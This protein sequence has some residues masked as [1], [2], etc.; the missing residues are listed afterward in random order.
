MRLSKESEYGLKGLVFLAQQPPGTVML[1]RD[2][3]AAQGLPQSFLAKIFRKFVQHGL[4]RSYRGKERGF[5]LAK[6]PTAVPLK[7]VLHAVEGP[8]L[9]ERCV[10][11]NAHCGGDDP[12]PLHEAW[13]TVKPQFV[14]LMER[15][16]L[17]ALTQ[18]PA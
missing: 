12:C 16:T 10:F 18:E 2:V 1:L 5:A 7:E 4:V 14:E 6:P 15:M 13:S 3:A 8:D 11:G 17:A 9:Y